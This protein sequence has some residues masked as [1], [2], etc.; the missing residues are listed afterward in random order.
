MISPSWRGPFADPRFRRLLAGQSLSTFGDTALYLTL[1]IWAKTLTG[2][3]AAAGA[4]FLALGIPA[5]FAPAAGHLADRVRRRP[6]LVWTNALTAGLVLTL[7]A[8]RSQVQPGSFPLLLL[9]SL[10]LYVLNGLAVESMAGA[11]LA[12]L[13]RVGVM[14]AGLYVLSANRVTVWLGVLV[15]GLLFTFEARLWG[16]DPQVNRAF[17]DSLTGGLLLWI[18]VVVLREVF[19]PAT[20]ER[21]AIIGALCGF[22]IILM[23]FM[24]VHG[25]LE[26]LSPGS[27]HADGPPL[28]GRSDVALVAVF[29][30]FSTVTVTTVGF[31]D[32]VPVA[33]AARLATGLEAI[34]GQLYLAVVIATLVGRVV[35]RLS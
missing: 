6:L 4:V 7:L 11:M 34:V 28:A 3:N 35:A 18:F 21:D 31:G 33:P 8:V 20:A 32:I 5:L 24:R 13:G 22:L 23:I 30:Y 9:A 26:A 12:Q 15:V 16:L 29:Q 27:Y 10:L 19:R 17:Q 14:A 1:G 2:S 25:L